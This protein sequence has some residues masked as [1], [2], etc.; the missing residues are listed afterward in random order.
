MQAAGVF[1]ANND[2]ECVVEAERRHHFKLKPLFVLRLDFAEHGGGIAFDR[3]MQNR[4][5]SRAGIFDI[6][7]NAA[8]QKR[9]LADIAAGEIETPLDAQVR[10]RLEVFREDFAEKRLLG[11]I[12]RAD[13]DGV[14]S[15][16]AAANHESRE[17]A[18]GGWQ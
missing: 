4:G 14:A 12:L 9:L 13:N 15:P 10:A 8:R 1:A 2:C 5:E 7:V 16:R 3:I 11:K 18:N 6:G 17:E